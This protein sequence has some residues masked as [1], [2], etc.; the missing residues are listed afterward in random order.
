MSHPLWVRGLK[1]AFC[2]TTAIP[3]ENGIVSLRE[4]EERAIYQYISSDSYKIN[5][6]LRNGLRLDENDQLM[7]KNLDSALTKMPLYEGDLTRSLYFN[8]EKS[9]QM[10]LKAHEIGNVREY[11]EYISTTK[12]DIYNNKAQV[13]LYIL[14]TKK[15][16]DISQY[17]QSEQEIIYERGTKF[18]VKDVEEINGSYHI[19]LEEYD[20]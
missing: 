13:Q 3:I 10:F 19:L 9:V 5:E 7:I 11:N 20:E 4:E 18:V 2:R 17:N 14:N 12:G 15:G 6:K 16:R 8:S 1:Y